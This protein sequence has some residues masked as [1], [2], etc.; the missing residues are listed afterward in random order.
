MAVAKEANSSA[1][2]VEVRPEVTGTRGRWVAGLTIVVA[3]VGAAVT[4]YL[5]YLHHSS[6]FGGGFGPLCGE[7]TFDCGAVIRSAYGQLWGIPLSVFGTAGYVTIAA[8]A[9]AVMV[10]SS[11]AVL[12]G[13]ALAGGA[14]A[15]DA[16]LAY[17]MIVVLRH[18]CALCLTTYALNVILFGL[19]CWLWSRRKGAVETP[20]TGGRAAWAVVVGAVVMNAAAGAGAYY[21]PRWAFGSEAEQWRTMQDYLAGAGRVE[22]ST[23]D[24]QPVL[25][26]ADARNTIVV[27]EDLLC[28]ACRELEAT[29]QQLRQRHPADL[30]LVFLNYPLDTACNPGERPLNH[31]GACVLADEGECLQRQGLFWGYHD[32]LLADL[33]NATE[34]RRAA[35]LRS[36]PLDV[37]QYNAAAGANLGMRAVQMDLEL[38]R[39]IGV[40]T[41]PTLIINGRVMAGAM[42]LWLIEATMEKT[43]RLD[44]A[45]SSPRP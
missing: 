10:G 18:T 35:Y 33:N 34:T 30:R 4:V 8:C 14:L 16:Y 11:R 26:P 44:A 37:D 39:Q 23:F 31:P 19:F 1:Q 32:F 42:P 38:G 20:R 27:F 41:T 25:G 45:P 36:I 22:F 28:L 17:I 21:L 7:G 29:L 40:K 15:A 13:L 3:T 9:V 24:G 5:T 2:R 43:L 12:V 6:R